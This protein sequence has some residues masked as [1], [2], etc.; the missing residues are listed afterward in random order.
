MM[1][2]VIMCVDDEPV[3]LQS[4]IRQ[5][6]N[7]F[8]EQYEYETFDNA[9][10]GLDFLDELF[11]EGGKVELVISDWLMPRMRGDEFL[12]KARHRLPEIPFIMLSGQAD[13]N[14]VERARQEARLFR[15]VGKPW[16]KEQL[17]E[18]IQA[19]IACRHLQHTRQQP[20]KKPSTPEPSPQ[21]PTKLASPNP[22][23]PSP[24][25]T[26]MMSLKPKKE[27]PAQPT[28]K[29]EKRAPGGFFPM[30]L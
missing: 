6:E 11:A 29:K 3:V 4:L 14:A 12:I 1:K 7:S 18:V 20:E 15:F 17:L 27:Q 8:G 9:E 2:P 23:T 26:P 16:S 25:A 24:K 30:G 10:E 5:L 13:E 28:D 21:P 19:A 22:N